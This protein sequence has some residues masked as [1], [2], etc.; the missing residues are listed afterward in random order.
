MKRLAVQEDIEPVFS[1]YMDESCVPFLAYDPMSLDDFRLVYQGFLNSDG[2]YIYEVSG[3]VAGFYSITRRPGR[4]SHVAYLGALAVHPNFHGQGIALRI[5]NEE[6]D[7]LKNSGVKRVE[8]I[9]E[10]DNPRAV[11]FYEKLGFEIEGTLRKFYKRSHESDYID[12]YIM[13]VIFH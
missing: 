9:V 13:S 7:H 8:L 11:S 10:S 12:D 2:F 3:E 1:I 6:L 4:A 5:M